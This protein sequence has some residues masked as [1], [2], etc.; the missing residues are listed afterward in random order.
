M[1]WKA[2][3]EFTC[4]Y[5]YYILFFVILRISFRDT[6]VGNPSGLL[7]IVQQQKFQMVRVLKMK[8]MKK[9]N[10][11]DKSVKMREDR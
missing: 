6:L 5:V 4:I 8:T 10:R 3:R 2:S 9:M 11:L 1:V 7:G